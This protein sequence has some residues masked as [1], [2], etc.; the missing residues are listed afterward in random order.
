MHAGAFFISVKICTSV[1]CTRV[2]F[3]IL[4]TWELT[5]EIDLTDPMPLS[6]A[7]ELLAAV[8]NIVMVRLRDH[9]AYGDRDAMPDPLPAVYMLIAMLQDALREAEGVAKTMEGLNGEEIF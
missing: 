5:M 6:R 1:R 2:S 3:S 7:V 8:L 9:A 4:E